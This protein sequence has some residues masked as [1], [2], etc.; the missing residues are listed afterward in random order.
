MDYRVKLLVLLVLV[1]LLGQNSKL[2]HFTKQYVPSK[3]L[4]VAS[5]AS[6][7]LRT[8]LIDNYDSYTYNIWQSLARVN[9][10]EPIVV[11]NDYYKDWDTLL[12]N[13]DH[14]DNIVISPGPGSPLNHQDFGIS[15]D[16][17]LKAKVPILGVCLGH[18]GIAH[19]FGGEIKKAPEPM[20]GRLSHIIHKGNDIFADIEQNTSVVRYHSLIV[21]PL[22][23][24]LIPTAWTA[25]NI[26]MGLKHKSLPIYGVQF[27]PESVSTACGDQIF[28]NFNKIT[29]KYR[30]QN[31]F[32]KKL[33]NIDVVLPKETSPTTSLVEK[34]PF[35]TTYITKVKVNTS[36]ESIFE[37]LYNT[38]AASF[39]LDS[40]NNNY[41]NNTKV[42]NGLT[43]SHTSNRFS[44]MG[45]LDKN[46]ESSY[47]I[48]YLGQN[49]VVCRWANGSAEALNKNIFEYIDYLLAAEMN[50]FTSVV[51]VDA[52]IGAVESL[53]FNLKSS[54]IFG[55]LGYELRH[56]TT[57]VLTTSSNEGMGMNSR[58]NY[59]STHQDSFCGTKYTS[60]ISH[61][62][63]LYL[64]PSSYIV[65]DHLECEA[66]VVGT[67]SDGA[68]DGEQQSSLLKD[69]V[70]SIASRIGTLNS[71][72]SHGSSDTAS[73]DLSNVVLTSMRDKEKYFQNIED[74]LENITN[75]E[76]Y[77]VCLTLQFQGKV[78]RKRVNPL[79]VYKQLR[80]LNAS[81]MS[82][83]IHYDPGSFTDYEI[84][85]SSLLPW[86]KTGG[87]SLCCS[88]PE[89]YLSLD[90]SRCLESKPIKGTA[91]RNLGNQQEDILIGN[92]LINDEKSRA[93]NLLIVDLG[94]PFLSS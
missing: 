42:C 38:S 2:V 78:D 35:K 51:D 19:I 87:V 40:S 64:L 58:Y 86:Y 6:P 54:A 1:M 83:F 7:Q 91:R 29:Q 25:D 11:Y 14:F 36:T 43:S 9:G 41:N 32:N 61:P 89:R 18:Q 4:N 71:I 16:A 59:S 88:S 23:D 30:L 24:D 79:H 45:A 66:Y 75:G 69:K 33:P 84:S 5:S 67:C 46:D 12:R 80:R 73:P 22:P 8:L 15:A 37:L 27:H 82:S 77:E 81:P 68:L 10:I 72:K 52:S 17:I 31:N 74:C 53:P 39:W 48:E 50:N 26:I 92:D 49:S 85:K 63:A 93:E 57:H 44:F 47:A 76:T 60:D 70:R 3:S 90:S 28:K 65:Y 21:D 56:E 34:K 62:L 20:H 94:N 13:I 55:Y